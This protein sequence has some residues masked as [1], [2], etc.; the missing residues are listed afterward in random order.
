MNELTITE[1]Q[2]LEN[3][4]SVIERGLNTFVDVGEALL[5]IRDERLY[6]SEYPTF[7]AYCNKR[8][9]IK[10]RRAYQLMDAAKVIDNIKSCTIVQLPNT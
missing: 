10:E 4:E 3:L 8:W 2:T 1:N 9:G 7:E 5:T 6:R